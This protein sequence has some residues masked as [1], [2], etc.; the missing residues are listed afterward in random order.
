MTPR[1]LQDVRAPLVVEAANHPVSIEADA[2]L[3][4]GGVIVVP[5]IL[6]NAGG[7]TGSYFE[8]TSNLTGFRWSEE[9]F[10][11]Q[12]LDFLDRAFQTM[13]DVTSNAGWI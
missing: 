9:Q 11:D 12:L 3:S 13:W 8:W 4:E 5:D 1:T 7:V 10:N 6:A 2:I